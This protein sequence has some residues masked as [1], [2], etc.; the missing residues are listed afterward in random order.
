MAGTPRRYITNAQ[1]QHVDGFTL[2]GVRLGPFGSEDVFGALHKRSH[3]FLG[4]ENLGQVGA[5]AEES[6]L[7]VPE[8]HFKVLE[9][10]S[11]LNL[12]A[13]TRRQ[14]MGERMTGERRPAELSKLI[15]FIQEKESPVRVVDGDERPAQEPTDWQVV[16]TCLERAMQSPTGTQ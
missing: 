6:V 4:K 12:G 10:A 7:A 9:V 5:D 16:V 8:E 2:L 15:T 11:V 1:T 13:L 3:D 14:V